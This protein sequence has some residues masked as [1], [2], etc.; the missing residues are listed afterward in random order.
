MVA[1][2]DPS[3][4]SRRFAQ[5]R[6]V[7]QKLAIGFS[8]AGA[9]V[10][11]VVGATLW[12]I[13]RA[14]QANSLQHRASI[15]R[16][17]ATQLQYTASNMRAEQLAYVAGDGAGR[18][19][20][21]AASGRFQQS[22]NDLRGHA[23]TPAQTALVTKIST[24]Y[25]TFLAIDQLILNEI[26]AGN[27]NTAENLALGA[28][29]IGFTFMAEDAA[30]FSRDSTLLASSAS[31]AFGETTSHLRTAA[32]S[33]GLFAL[34]L[35][36]GASWLITH[37]IRRPLLQLEC[38]A[39]LAAAGDLSATTEL[40][41]EDETGKLATAFNFMLRQ[42]RA[43][44]ESLVAEHMRQDAARRVERAFDMAV[45]EQQVFDVVSRALASDSLGRR[46]ELLVASGPKGAMTS[47]SMGD[48]ES[49]VA[50][51]TVDTLE[52]CPAIGS[53]KHM[54][55]KSSDDIDACPFLR[56]RD[57]GPCSAT[58][59][60][61]SFSGKH[62]W[63][64]PYH[65]ARRGVDSTRGRRI[66][67]FGGCG[68]RFENRATEIQCRYQVAGHDRPAH[69]PVQSASLRKS[70]EAAARRGR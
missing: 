11:L 38:S 45:S 21:E 63:C 67:G 42:L 41:G 22:L 62:F 8:A 1:S 12:S 66:A 55:F 30:T 20:F 9:V 24:G 35:V 52:G 3:P 4:G 48:S 7:G 31:E 25:Q 34:T 51:C 37:L 53:G 56:D 70:R 6:S 23:N 64:D 29:Q 61:V 15:G 36:A 33:L 17:L 50:G 65:W 2:A 58:C 44:E 69:R 32:I 43:R 39:E 57:G 10:A 68:S 47:V 19:K 13:G 18:D 49:P 40:S 28:E 60:P 16:E 14:D 26:H 46:T 59:V 5:D 27:P 54:D